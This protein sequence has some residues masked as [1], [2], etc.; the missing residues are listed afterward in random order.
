MAGGT[1]ELNDRDQRVVHPI[2]RKLMETSKLVSG[3][4]VIYS[5]LDFVR[6]FVQTCLIWSIS[7]QQ[8]VPL[9]FSYVTLAKSISR[10]N[11]L[12][13]FLIKGV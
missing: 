9:S 13:S 7:F 1:A 12:L 3:F 5:A 11:F 2:E 8:I 6:C 10:H 4:I